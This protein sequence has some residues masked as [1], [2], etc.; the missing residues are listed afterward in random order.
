M[1]GGLKKLQV[2]NGEN[3]IRE[4]SFIDSLYCKNTITWFTF[5]GRLKDNAIKMVN[6]IHS[7]YS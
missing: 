2:R 4:I 5:Y 3:K 6:R 1:D 7:V